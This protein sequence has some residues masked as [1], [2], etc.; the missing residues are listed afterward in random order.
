MDRRDRRDRP[1]RSSGDGRRRAAPVPGRVVVAGLVE[2]DRGRRSGR[3]RR[4]AELRAGSSRPF[5][6]ERRMELRAGESFVRSTHRLTNVGL[7]ADA[8]HVGDPPG[9]R[10][11]ARRAGSRSPAGRGRSTRAMPTSASHRGPG[12]RGRTC[13]RPAVRSTCRWRARPIHRRGSSCSSTS[14]RTAGW[15][16]PTRRAGPA[17]RC[18]SIRRSSRWRGCGASTAAG[19]GCTRSRSRPGRRI[20]RG[21]T[22]S[23]PPGGPGRWRPARA[24]ETEVRFIAFDGVSSVEGVADGVVHGRG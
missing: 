12:S 2:P 10:R 5:R 18:R 1:D 6:I 17:S 4:R 22:R 20:R 16:S 21:S 24:I 7:R 13:R 8:V 11:P 14:C 23:S 9:A 3:G 19:E 15:P